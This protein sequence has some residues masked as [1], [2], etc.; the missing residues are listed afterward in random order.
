MKTTSLRSLRSF[1]PKKLALLA[2]L[3][4]LQPFIARCAESPGPR[5]NPVVIPFEFRR[6]HVLIP[7]QVAGTN[8]QPFIL[9]TGYSMTMLPPGLGDALQLRRRGEVTIVGIAGEEEANV[10]EGPRM[11]FNGLTWTLRR[12]AAFPESGRGRKREGILG[13]GFFRRFVVEI[14]QRAKSVTLH[15]PGAFQYA[16]EGE[17]LPLRFKRGSS[18]PIVTASINATNEGAVQGEF[19][20]DTGCDSALC[21]ARDFTDRHRLVPPDA[22]SSGRTGVGGGT[23]T[24][25]GRLASLHL[26]KLRVER[27]SAEFFEQG[28]PA[29]D[30]LAG[31]IG[32]EA[33]RDFKSIFD[34]SR[35]RLILE[36]LASGNR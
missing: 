8:A 4:A 21:L 16:G 33:F 24:R 14:D 17:I 12:V 11:E 9:D 28:S 3:S 15:E 31:H 30:G 19:E 10:F 27:P 34:Y 32:L 26:G 6:G 2:T 22:R 13:S 5:T 7:A 35:Q 36:P 20:V 25:A 1:A 18:T 23:R 29:D